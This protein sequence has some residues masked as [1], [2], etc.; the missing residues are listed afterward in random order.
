MLHSHEFVKDQRPQTEHLVT[1]I[2][3]QRS[4]GGMAP[5]VSVRSQQPILIESFVAEMDSRV[6]ADPSAGPLI[7]AGIRVCEETLLGAPETAIAQAVEI[8][9]V[10]DDPR[11]SICP[12]RGVDCGGGDEA[13][14]G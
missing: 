8:V 9:S 3:I 2:V 1:D 10:D 5:G 11:E 6:A 14:E 13:L 4:L 12:S 7:P